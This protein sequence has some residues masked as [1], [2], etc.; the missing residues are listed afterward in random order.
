MNERKAFLFIL[1]GIFGLI[2]FMMAEPF[3]G[4][5][6]GAGLLAFLLYPIHRRASKYIPDRISG[7]LVV[8]LGILVLIV[9]FLFAAMAVFEDARDLVNDV[10]R[11]EFIDTGEIEQRVFDM[12]G[13]EIDVEQSIDSL[14]RRFTETSLGGFTQF[15]QFFTHFTIGITIM[16]FLMYYLIVDG[17]EFVQWLRTIIP[18][19][20]EI[21]GSLLDEIEMTSWAVIKGHVMVAIIQGLVAGLGLF[22]TGI[23]NY[24]FWTFVMILLGFI[25][26]FGTFMIWGPATVYLFIIGEVPSAVFLGIYGLII[27]SLTDNIIRPFAVDR[28]SNL[29]PAVILIGVIGGVYIFGAVGLFIGPILLGIFKSVLLVFK[30]NYE[31]L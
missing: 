14:F 30:N 22:L 9:P 10:N 16:M 28:G 3:L 19:P 12:T 11:T 8:F 24:F 6:I 5:I 1:A 7:F 26:I 20:E 13:R 18:L 27:V 23:P 29:H 17:K 25:P 31:D 15:I 2:A 21:Q 4:Y